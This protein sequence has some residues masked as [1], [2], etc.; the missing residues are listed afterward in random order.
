MYFSWSAQ[1]IDTTNR[2]FANS[3]SRIS[4]TAVR[5]GS[6]NNPR[7]LITHICSHS[8]NTPLNLLRR[9]LN[10]EL[11]SRDI[12][13]MNVQLE[14]NTHV[15][16]ECFVISLSLSLSLRISIYRISNLKIKKNT[17]LFM[18]RLR[19]I[20]TAYVWNARVTFNEVVKERLWAIDECHR[21]WWNRRLAICRPTLTFGH[22]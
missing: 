21:K 22:V 15:P 10:P 1:Q 4:F 18:S 7:G 12:S 2:Q 16:S 9:Y 6:G 8:L 17:S 11:A 5:G 13:Y 14:S 3:R 19:F 20:V